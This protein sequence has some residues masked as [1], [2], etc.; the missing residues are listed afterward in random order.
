VFCVTGL[1]FVG[2]RTPVRHGI[3]DRTPV[4]PVIHLPVVPNEDRSEPGRDLIAKSPVIVER[5][6]EIPPA[7]K[8]K[9][10]VAEILE[11][12]VQD[13]FF[14]YNRH[15]LLPEAR[16]A[17]DQDVAALKSMFE[18]FP[19]LLLAV[20]G[21]C[22]ERGS[23]EYNLALGYLRARTARDFLVGL[24]LAESRLAVISY[25]KERPQCTEQEESCWQRNRRAHIAEK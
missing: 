25:G 4:E 23:A 15:D 2:C 12:G 21:H 11:G 5:H 16:S 8:E 24:G 10:T 17:L 14:A 20:E 6:P 18:D 19:D 1:L 3:L 22:D 13:A 7:P 9:K